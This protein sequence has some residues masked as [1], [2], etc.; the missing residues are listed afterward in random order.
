ESRFNSWEQAEADCAA[1]GMS[2]P[3]IKTDA[4]LNTLTDLMKNA[5][6]P[7][8]GIW[9]GLNDK[10]TERT[11]VWDDG[12]VESPKSP[13]W[14]SG[15]KQ[16]LFKHADLQ[17]YYEYTSKYNSYKTNANNVEDAVE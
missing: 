6:P 7:L 12:T 16:T 17:L 15:G 13:Y 2:L 4:D 9:V 11:F 5:T 8:L 3:I 14:H 1:K 10:G